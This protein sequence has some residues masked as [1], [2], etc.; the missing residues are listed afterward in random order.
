MKVTFVNG[1]M[2]GKQMEI[3]DDYNCQRILIRQ[4][5]DGRFYEVRYE[6]LPNEPLKLGY[7]S[8]EEIV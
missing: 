5:S 6:W 4:E 2:E 3:P 8:R 7:V 1:P